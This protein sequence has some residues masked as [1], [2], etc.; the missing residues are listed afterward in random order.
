MTTKELL[1]MTE[2]SVISLEAT[3]RNEVKRIADYTQILTQ[4]GPEDPLRSQFEGLLE[5]EKER[6]QKSQH[7]LENLGRIHTT[8][9]ET[10]RKLEA[11]AA[12]GR[13]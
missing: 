6:L 8:V 5:Q 9:L 2:D 1:A 13:G 12:M 7:S 3:I 4:L 11:K 10:L